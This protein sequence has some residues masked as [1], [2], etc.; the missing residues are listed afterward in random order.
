M[1]KSRNCQPA[2]RRMDLLIR[3]RPNTLF[4]VHMI[5]PPNGILIDTAD[6][7]HTAAKVQNAF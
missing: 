3:P 4:W 2:R 5:Q 7:A 1:P 6:F